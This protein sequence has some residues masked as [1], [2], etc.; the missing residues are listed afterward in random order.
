MLPG[1]A[2]IE[3]LGVRNHAID[4]AM[5]RANQAAGTGGGAMSFAAE[6]QRLQS[7]QDS[8]TD[9]NRPGDADVIRDQAK[10]LVSSAFLMPL[11]KM[12][13]EDPFKSE[14]FHGGAGEEQFGQMFDERIADSIV[15]GMNFPL[16]DEI[17][18]RFLEAKGIDPDKSGKDKSAGGGEADVSVNGR[19]GHWPGETVLNRDRLNSGGASVSEVTGSL[20]LNNQSVLELLNN[21]NA[22]EALNGS[23]V[24]AAI[25]ESR[26]SRE[27]L[28]SAELKNR[29]ELPGEGMNDRQIGTQ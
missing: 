25:L 27:Q 12:A 17:T 21:P 20:G 28:N 15:N 29:V 19:I 24:P 1:S 14:L 11:L 4:G 6:M 23:G 22:V 7:M 5:I 13:R 8:A 16:V 26:T 9:R 3:G 2:G 10:K 18:R